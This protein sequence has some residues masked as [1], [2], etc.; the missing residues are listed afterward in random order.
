[1]LVLHYYYAFTQP[2][3]LA[4]NLIQIADSLSKLGQV[5]GGFLEGLTMYSPEFQA[6]ST[7]IFGNVFTVKF[8]PKSDTVSPQLS[9]NY[10][11]TTIYIKVGM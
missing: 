4:T 1:M 10:V 3:Q 8:V 7:K 6:G 5:H 9:G 11:D 2:S